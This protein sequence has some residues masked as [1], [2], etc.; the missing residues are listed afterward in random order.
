ETGHAG[1]QAAAGFDRRRRLG[2]S[3]LDLVAR[4]DRDAFRADRHA[5]TALQMRG[6]AQLV[7]LDVALPLEALLG[8]GEQQHAVADG[9]PD[10]EAADLIRAERNVGREE[11]DGLLVVDDGGKLEKLLPDRV[12][13][14]DLV[15][16]DRDGVDDHPP[17]LQCRDSLLHHQE[18]SLDHDVRL[19]DEDDLDHPALDLGIEVPTEARCRGPQP[20]AGLLEREQDTLFTDLCAAVDEL[21][22]ERRLPG[23]GDARNEQ[24][25]AV[26]NAWAEKIVELRDAGF[27]T[28]RLDAGPRFTPNGDARCE[29]LDAVVRNDEG[30]LVAAVVRAAHLH[31]PDE[32]LLLAR[33]LALVH[34]DHPIDDREEGIRRDVLRAE[35]AEQ[36][37]RHLPGHQVDGELVT[38]LAQPLP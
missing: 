13:V 33:L 17:R 28:L 26:W 19:R 22:A 4:I 3:G 37:R 16:E 32:A 34:Q 24:A 7:D 6:V 30:M 29:N 36:E 31:D 38:E 14:L 21:E 27:N 11:A 20:L 25:R 10:A 18:V 9:C 5:V 12:R 23:S 35:F 15:H 1:R 8:G 2:E